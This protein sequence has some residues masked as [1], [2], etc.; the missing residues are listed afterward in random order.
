MGAVLGE[1]KTGGGGAEG[2]R[3]DRVEQPTANA[4]RF[5]RTNRRGVFIPGQCPSRWQ[6]QCKTSVDSRS[7]P[8]EALAV[9]AHRNCTNTNR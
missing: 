5:P 3:F 7:D 8:P 2:L 4:N 1:V 9:V 6:A